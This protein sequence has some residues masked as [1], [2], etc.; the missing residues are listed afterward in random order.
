[1]ILAVSGGIVANPDVF[2]ALL[3][4]FHTIWIKATP[5]EHMS[6]VRAQGDTRPMAGNPEAMEQLKFILTSRDALYDQARAKLDT[7]G[8][9]VSQSLEDLLA[10]IDARGFLD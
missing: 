9:S 4:H 3:T 6:R 7:T 1:M 2:K 8:K 10:L 5:A